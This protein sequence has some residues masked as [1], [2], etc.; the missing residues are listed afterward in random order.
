MPVLEKFKDST[1]IKII[2]GVGHQVYA[3]NINAF[4]SS[5]TGFL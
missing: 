3:E 4:N 1:T 5:V 2:E